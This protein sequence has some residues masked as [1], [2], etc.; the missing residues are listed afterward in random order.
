MA[1]HGAII[2]EIYNWF[3]GWNQYV[4]G[5][6]TGAAIALFSAWLQIRSGARRQSEQ[7]S[8]TATEN[9]K[10]RDHERRIAEEEK[11]N[12]L[13]KEVYLPLLEAMYAAYAF[14]ERVG[15]LSLNEFFAKVPLSNLNRH[16]SLVNLLGGEETNK[17]VAFIVEYLNLLHDEFKGPVYELDGLRQASDYSKQVTEAIRARFTSLVL[18][19]D[20][21]KPK[22]HRKGVSDTI[23]SL[24]ETHN[25]HN[26]KWRGE[27]LTYTTAKL[28]MNAKANILLANLLPKLRSA[29]LRIRSEIHLPADEEKLSR[30]IAFSKDEATKSFKRRMENYDR[31]SKEV[32]EQPN[33]QTAHTPAPTSHSPTAVPQSGSDDTPSHL[34]SPETPP[35][36]D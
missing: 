4:Q 15:D 29:A 22:D 19:Y 30:S 6:A 20:V 8:A 27:F 24:L 16:Q 23:D 7:L 18:E 21:N 12:S 5:A 9:E 14:L 10:D 34:S 11:T 32:R 33:P 26:E 25:S 31:I 36:E 2:D 17:D 3:A 13:R 28:T 35:P 1:S